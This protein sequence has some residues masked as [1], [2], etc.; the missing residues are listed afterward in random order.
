MGM[1]T[2]ERDEF[3]EPI[4]DQNG[5]TIYKEH[6][7]V[8]NDGRTKQA[9]RDQTDIVKIVTKFQK[10]GT[11]S[12]LAKHGPTYGDFA[13]I[14]LLQAYENIAKAETIFNELPS[15]LRREFENPN[16]FLK[17]VNDPANANRLDELLPSLAEP[18]FQHRGR[19]NAGGPPESPPGPPE[20]TPAPADPQVSPP[21]DE[22]A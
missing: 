2:I 9:F 19:L 15:E 12:H 18:G 20:S 21:G 1:N 4:L 22:A 13:N 6:I 3:D 17:F 5:N 10:E 16:N 7:P 8:Y 14:D 11:I